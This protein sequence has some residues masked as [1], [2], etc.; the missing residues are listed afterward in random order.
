M[1]KLP[2]AQTIIDT[3]QPRMDAYAA[4]TGKGYIPMR[5]EGN[6]KLLTLGTVEEHL[7]GQRQLGIY[8]TS[9]DNTV[10]WIVA[11]V[12]AHDATDAEKSS[13]AQSE[14]KAIHGALLAA[15]FAAYIER[16]KSGTGYHIWSLFD[17]PVD[18]ARA[19]LVWLHIIRNSDQEYKQFDRLFP[20]QNR[21][22]GKG[23]GNLIALPW[24]MDS[25]GNNNSVFVD[26]DTFAAIEDQDE[27]LRNMVKITE[28]QLDAYIAT[29][30]LAE[31]ASRISKA[32]AV[33]PAGGI[34]NIEH[35]QFIQHADNNQAD[36]PEPLWHALA[37]NLAPFSEDGRSLY[38]QL[39]RGHA[40]Y[41]EDE[42]NAK[43]D[44]AVK[45]RESGHHPV[46]CKKL[47]ELG[48]TC[49]LLSTCPAAF[50]AEYSDRFADVP[51]MEDE[52]RDYT[53]VR[54]QG[55][56]D[57]VTEHRFFLGLK[58]SDEKTREELIEQL[59]QVENWTIKQKLAIQVQVA[60]VGYETTPKYGVRV[61]DTLP[62]APTEVRQLVVPPPFVLNNDGLFIETLEP[63]G[64]PDNKEPKR[65]RTQ[66]ARQ[67]LIQTERT[68]DHKGNPGSSMNFT[69][70]DDDGSWR[71]FGIPRTVSTDARDLARKL[72]DYGYGINPPMRAQLAIFVFQ[73]ETV[74]KKQL[75]LNA[76][77]NRLGWHTIDDVPCFVPYDRQVKLLPLDVG[78]REMTEK[79]VWEER[80][81]FSGWQELWEELRPYPIAKFVM[82][83][84]LSSSLLPLLGTDGQSHSVVLCR[85]GGSGKSATQTIAG[86]MYGDASVLLRN[87]SST[88]NGFER[89]LELR[90][91]FPSLFEDLHLVAEEQLRKS[92]YDL[93]N[94]KAKTRM[95]ANGGM[96][97]TAT[98]KTVLVG[99]SET[100][101]RSKSDW[102]GF[103]RRN[104]VIV[105]SIFNK[106]GLE[107]GKLAQH[108]KHKA[109]DNQ[110]V[111]GRR[112]IEE[113]RPYMSNQSTIR[114]WYNTNITWFRDQLSAEFG[115]DKVVSTFAAFGAIH[116]VTGQMLVRMLEADDQGDLDPR[117][118]VLKVIQDSLRSMKEVDF[119][120][121]YMIQILEWAVAEEDAFA[122]VSVRGK[123]YGVISHNRPWV[124]YIEGQV[125]QY[126]KQSNNLKSLDMDDIKEQWALRGWIKTTQ[127]IDKNTGKEK[128]RYSI[129]T[130]IGN[131]TG[132]VRMIQ[133]QL[134]S[135]TLPNIGI[136]S[137]EVDHIPPEG[138]TLNEIDEI[139][140]LSVTSER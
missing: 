11:D 60:K 37:T 107:V 128:T 116:A 139:L 13:K 106:E 35:C 57:A 127:E 112:W 9:L 4:Y 53:H 89:A 65:V 115:S 114:D 121:R 137:R 25:V 36:L 58:M 94:E 78:D 136:A 32:R 108:L 110:A 3:I 133:V 46:S 86:Y 22:S 68:N 125:I 130:R 118:L 30:N 39:S 14:A 100:D 16:S 55:K 120:T 109:E 49:P 45:D 74:N 99:S 44:H 104:I 138:S 117:Y 41:T 75:E 2:K 10:T 92:F 62:D 77:V 91:H 140:Q 80:G 111:L 19:R 85:T 122:N 119:A 88:Q 52:M 12:D 98:Y 18:A 73:F 20:A 135:P 28:S 93:F 103:L 105:E 123:R 6:L 15:G 96:K 64:D 79:Q 129:S 48:F 102:I 113:L 23:L 61:E 82:I 101:L 51:M 76:T 95:S 87:W 38:H 1:V 63:S 124:G 97:H 33:Q 126:L 50:A 21:L 24:R 54:N 7:R 72:S 67:A 56:K 31:K 42:T 81:S 70:K 84:S 59:S 71:T 27:Y 132:S 69:Y 131:A 26:N 34:Q 66:I 90:T 47:A 5:E 83:A 40:K 17:T 43:F 8:S 134:D 29:H